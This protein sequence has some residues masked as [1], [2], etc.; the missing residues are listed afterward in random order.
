[1]SV[2]GIALV[3]RAY[4]G[5]AEPAASALPQSVEAVIASPAEPNRELKDGKVLHAARINGALP[6]IDGSLSDEIWAGAARAAGFVQRDPDNGSPMTEETYIQI[7]YDDRYL[8]VAA[9]CFDAMPDAIRAGLSRR[10]DLGRTDELVLGFDPR[11]DHQTG[12]LFRTNPSAVQ[13][14]ASFFNDESQDQDYNAVWEVRTERTARGWTAEFRIPFSQMRFSTIPEPGQVWG[15]NAARE[16]RRKGEVGSWIPRPRGVRGDVSLFGHLVFDSS[17]PAPRRLELVPYLAARSENVPASALEAGAS[18]GLDVR[19][20]LGTG[21]T[22]SGTFNPDFGQVEQDPAVLNL[23]VFETFFPEKR[24]FFLEDSRTFVPPHGLFQLF[25]SRRIGRSPGRLPLAE[26]ERL[27][28]RPDDTTILGAAKLTGKGSGWTYGIMTA[29][30]SREYAQVESPIAHADGTITYLRGERLI[31]PATSYSVARVQRDVMSGTSNVGAIVTS[32]LRE[33]GENAFTGGID[34][35][36]RW[37]RNRVNWN[38]HWVTTRAP[39]PEGMKTSGGG[40]TSFSVTRKHANVSAHYDHF[41]RDFRVNDIGFFRTRGNR[42]QVNGGLE[43]GNPD[44]WKKLRSIWAFTYWNNDWTDEKLL[45]GR[46]QESGLNIRFLNFWQIVG[47]GWRS[48][49]IYDDLDTRGGPPILRPGN[50]GVFYRVNSDSRRRWSFS[51]YGNRWQSDV[52]RTGGNWSPGFSY[53]PTDRLQ[54]SI[55]LNYNYGVDDGQWITNED[56]NGDSVIDHVYG[57]LDRDVVDITLRGTYAFTRDLTVQA[58]LQPFVAVGDYGHIR[59]LAGP[60]TY[61]FEPVTIPFNPDF[62]RKSLR[63]NIVMRWEFQP[64]STLFVVWDLSQTDL[65]R[66][67]DFSPL[68]DLRTAFGADATHIFMVKATYWLNR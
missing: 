2:L 22:L 17:L 62:S 20:G 32:V 42:H 11:H 15:F 25:H 51:F 61:Q 52:G 57:T 65:A 31:E 16:I 54:T 5:Q 30:T 12:Y 13:G 1:V 33:Q 7:A 9:T 36:L 24:P 44:P 39:G 68:R 37:D 56:T 43:V 55:S 46:Y 63:G 58:Y 40:V 59:R 45:I 6:V 10:D 35:S 14:D 64:G 4:A 28:E 66:P 21:A 18:A 27:I 19:I 8:Y 26:G 3:A 47:G 41:G 50:V 38:G 29:M 34:Y 48:F 60:K 53:Q 23:S 67:G 49:E